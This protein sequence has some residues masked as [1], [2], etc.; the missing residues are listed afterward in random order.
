MKRFSNFLVC[1]VLVLLPSQLIAQIEYAY[2][3][4]LNNW[5][6]YALKGKVKRTVSKRYLKLEKEQTA[7]VSASNDSL[8]FKETSI[9]TFDSAGFLCYSVDYE[10]DFTDTIR[11]QFFENGRLSIQKILWMECR[12]YYNFKGEIE[13]IEEMSDY[14]PK[15]VKGTYYFFYSEGRLTKREYSLNLENYPADMLRNTYDQNEKTTYHYDKLGQLISETHYSIYDR[16]KKDRIVQV[17]YKDHE[18]SYLYNAEG[19][20]I[21]S[22]QIDSR[23]RNPDIEEIK[24]LYSG[25]VLSEIHTTNFNGKSIKMKTIEKIENGLIISK[26]TT[27]YP[28]L[29]IFITEYKYV[30]DEQGNWLEE[31]VFKNGQLSEKTTRTIE[32]FD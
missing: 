10:G 1:L 20:L 22:K 4:D 21:L 2:P 30:F 31:E 16:F 9:Y 5:K 32:Y 8:F 13:R 3:V 7:G 29:R 18:I 11:L 14:E 25:D 6:T 27:R 17:A 12:I 19:L 23:R 26:I 15:F 28:E 24:Y